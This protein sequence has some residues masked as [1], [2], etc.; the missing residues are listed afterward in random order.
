L[1]HYHH[2][3]ASLSPPEA[4]SRN[5]PINGQRKT[6]FSSRTRRQLQPLAQHQYPP[7]G[8]RPQGGGARLTNQ[9][10]H[11]RTHLCRAG[12]CPNCTKNLPTTATRANN[13][14]TTTAPTND[15][16]TEK[17]NWSTKRSWWN[18]S[19]TKKDNE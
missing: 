2:H 5:R 4:T 6:R 7:Q 11:C 12:G 9:C 8:R 17:R 1:N 13:T 19:S 10:Q 18:D 15:R 16:W 14:S 3:L